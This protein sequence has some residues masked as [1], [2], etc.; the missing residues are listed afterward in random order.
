MVAFL[1]F[2]QASRLDFSNI[3]LFDVLEFCDLLIED[4]RLNL[5]FGQQVIKFAENLFGCVIIA[6]EGPS[7]FRGF[8]EELLNLIQDVYLEKEITVA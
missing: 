6:D 5:V 7:V 8:R 3:G 4:F 1:A 2:R